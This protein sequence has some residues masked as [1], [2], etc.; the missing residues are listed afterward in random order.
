MAR[1]IERVVRFEVGGD[2]QHIY[3]VETETRSGAFK[4]IL[5]PIWMVTYKYRSLTCRF[6]VNG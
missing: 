4:H 5:L 3:T 1:V 6:A 2:P